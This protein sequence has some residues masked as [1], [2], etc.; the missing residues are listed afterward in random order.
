MALIELSD[1]ERS[2]TAGEQTVRVL[3]GIDLCI[4][5]G[6]MVAII[7]QSGSG[8][9]TLMNILGCLD[10]PTTGSYRF[11]GRDVQQ[12]SDLDLAELR[13]DHFGFIFQR[14]Q[15][16]AELDA[17]GNVEIPAVYRGAARK[18]RRERAKALLTRLGLGERLGNK[19]GALSGGQQ[20]RVSVAR[21]LINGG[22]VILAD[23]PTGALDS[24]SGAELM[25]LLR[26]LHA[27]GHTVILVTHDPQ[28][29]EA[30][31]RVIEIS[32]GEITADTRKRPHNA[33]ARVETDHPAAS[34][35]GA[36]A[37][38]LRE[39]TR[40]ALK[41]M[42]SH[43]LRS[44][45]TMLGII[46]GITSVVSVV[47]LGN[48]SQQKV[49][50]NISS[51]GTSTIDIRPGTGF[52]DRR[53]N[54]VDTLVGGDADALDGRAFA[55]SVSPEVSTTATVIHAGT[56]ASASVKGVS[57]GYFR[58]GA[59]SV[60]EGATFTE[61][62]LKARAQVAV[63]D[64]DAAETFFGTES[65]LGQRVMIGR[66]PLQVIGVVEASG[67]SFGPQ[68]IKVFTPY[69]TAMA[70]ITGGETVDSISVQV[71]DD[72]DMDQAEQE[73]TAILSQRHGTVDFFLTNTDTIRETIQ[74]TSQ[75]LTWLISAIAL[76][77]LF[78]G[79]IGVM[80]IM[81]VSVTERTREI[82]IRKAVGARQSDITAQ[83]LIEAVLVCLIGG[84]LGV[85]L[86]FGFGALMGVV[87]PSMRLVYSG[88]TVAAAFGSATLIGV[89]FGYLPARSAS[90]LD[91]VVALARE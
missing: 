14:Y 67:A 28:I 37:D 72:Y 22:E 13:R 79:G 87:A 39:A 10:R 11:D 8:K 30:A 23:E 86:A 9:S 76:I 6:E 84:A 69:T 66:V 2:F 42:A 75:T 38:R 85:V 89:V 65:P 54:R 24:A 5:A 32:D 62:D 68:S 19:P 50:E 46:I 55:A 74:S 43:K 61:A 70:R 16:M 7:G 83:F 90:K 18:A 44:F 77:S 57:A 31:D 64:S 3:R 15:L 49:L 27:E 41:S 56:S 80:N 4:E 58:L 59:Y 29:A 21:A 20:Q 88:A 48:G 34:G 71:V 12:L 25:A 81:L 26:E 17:V 82:G 60:T 45:L 63:L 53:A 47:A 40:M 51:I 91:P 1:I 78:V 36:L 73:I 52:G 33:P 35:L